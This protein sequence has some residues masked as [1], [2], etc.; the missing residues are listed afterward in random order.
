M[1]NYILLYA[2]IALELEV[3]V[4]YYY[5]TAFYELKSDPLYLYYVQAKGTSIAS[6]KCD[7]LQSGTGTGSSRT[8]NPPSNLL[9]RSGV[10]IKLTNLLRRSGIKTDIDISVKSLRLAN[11]QETIFP[12]TI[13][14]QI[15]SI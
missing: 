4:I 7:V 8:F 2:G 6:G 12:K 3:H 15:F 9:R 5:Y 14:E 11:Q 13:L 10:P 1:S